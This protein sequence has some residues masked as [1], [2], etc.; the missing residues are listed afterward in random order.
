MARSHEEEE[1]RRTEERFRL[2]VEN[3]ADYAIYALDPDGRVTT[4][5]LGAQRLKGYDATEAIGL[6]FEVFFS[7]EDAAAGK[8]ARELAAA[9]AVGRFEDEGWRI[10]KDGTRFWANVVL[11]VLHDARGTEVGFAKITRDLTARKQAEETARRLAR[12]QAAREAAEDAQRLIRESEEKHRELS[13]RLEIVFDGVADGI[14]VQDASGHI[15]FANQAAAELCGFESAAEL[16]STPLAQVAA[17]FDL[18]DESGRP[19][20]SERLPARLA[21]AGKGPSSCVV[22]L[23]ERAS[24]RE[25]WVLLRA[26]AVVSA[27]GVPELAINIWHD[28]TGERRREQLGTWLADAAAA[29]GESLDPTEMLSG[30]ARTLVPSLGDWASVHLREGEQLRRVAVA[31]TDPVRCEEALSHEPE[32]VPRDAANSM[33]QIVQSG[34]S[35]AYNDISDAMLSRAARDPEQLARLRTAGIQAALV[36]PI[37]LRD[38]VVGILAVI[39][40]ESNRRYEASDVALI[41]EIGRRAGVALENAQLYAAAQSAVRTAEE[42][43]RAKDEFLATVSHELRTPLSA[44]VGWA[45]LLTKTVTDPV[46]TKGIEVIH[47]NA[48]AQVR[49]IDDILD[50]SRVV[51]GKL[52]IDARPTDLVSI[53]RDAIEVVRPS[54]DAKQIEIRLLSSGACVLIGDADRLQQVVWNLLSNAVKFTDRGGTIGVRVECTKSSV[55]LTVTDSG[56]GIDAAFLPSVFDRF[57]QAD[58]SMTRRVG[59]LGLGLAL[60]R[61]IVELHGGRVRAESA[62]TGKGSV[63]TVT[64]PV[65]AVFAHQALRQT[66]APHLPKPDVITASSLADMHVLVVDDEA[67]ARDLLATVLSGAGALVSTAASASA[68]FEELRR[69]RPDILVSDIGMPDEDGFS[70]MRRIRALPA[71]E[72]GATPAIALS[73]FSRDEDRARALAAGFSAHIGKPVDPSVLT[74]A[75]ARLRS[76]IVARSAQ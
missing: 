35:E 53:V 8:P 23:R 39:A 45:A 7:R 75:V 13:Q 15:V 65:R 34:R 20:D 71:E 29:L 22:R 74:A 19:F 70:L 64:L 61:H 4:W 48:L 57:R 6:H 3:V 28:I 27:T 47:R 72:G 11:T 55:M 25:R 24:R 10:R 5:N 40:T 26:S 46:V 69:G 1:L 50:V 16:M 9:R 51:T 68:G 76:L 59:G 56:R 41:E 2:L 31:H 12:E 52:R 18:F 32:L 66:P 43:S 62:G 33:W 42:A 21:L 54:A 17:S 38:E 30:L 14:G 37:Q 73:A 60:V 67:D 49:I 63:F 58:A 44:I 36:A